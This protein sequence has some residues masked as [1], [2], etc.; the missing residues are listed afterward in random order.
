[1][2][3]LAALFGPPAAPNDV[4]AKLS[5]LARIRTQS[6]QLVKQN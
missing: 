5:E 3:P 6:E 4:L 1:M 2:V